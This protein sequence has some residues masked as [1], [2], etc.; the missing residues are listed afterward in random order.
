ML[1]IYLLS[2]YLTKLCLFSCG[3]GNYE[4]GIGANVKRDLLLIIVVEDFALA[5]S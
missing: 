1:L 5:N 4:M 2:N 3:S